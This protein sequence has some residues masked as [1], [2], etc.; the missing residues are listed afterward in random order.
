MFKLFRKIRYEHMKNN[1]T[2][3]YLKYAIGEIILVVLGIL[4]ALQINNW[5]QFAK[6]RIKEK[7]YLTS[8]HNEFVENKTQFERNAKVHK[9]ISESLGKIIN[10]FPI[11]E[12]NWDSVMTILFRVNP[13]LKGK[14]EFAMDVLMSYTFNPSQSSLNALVNS[15]DIDLV[16]DQRLRELLISWP[17]LVSDY[18]EHEVEARILIRNQF[19]PIINKVLNR[20]GK[21]GSFNILTKREILNLQNLIIA[22]FS[23]LKWVYD[24]PIEED[25]ITLDAINRII[26]L[27]SPSTQ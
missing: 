7:N 26:E 13:A 9:R 5:S 20:H 24:S 11:T 8:I 3:K 18:Q 12:S 17:D 4:I 22:R 6:D 27:T 23:G 1:K 2:S 21:N 16:L 14:D 19:E 10:M 15:S 25:K